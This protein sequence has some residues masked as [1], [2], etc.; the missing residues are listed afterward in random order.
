MFMAKKHSTAMVMRQNIV[1]QLSVCFEVIYGCNR[2]PN[3][4]FGLNLLY[5]NTSLFFWIESH[6]V[7]HP[8]SFPV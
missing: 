8:N 4:N 7:A 2:F 3:D 6:W 1:K 5:G